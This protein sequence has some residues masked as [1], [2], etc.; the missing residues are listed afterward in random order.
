MPKKSKGSTSAAAEEDQPEEHQRGETHQVAHGKCAKL[1]TN[2][3]IY[4]SDNQ[5]ALVAG[6]RGPVLLEDF[7]F[8][9]KIF[10][11][12]H[13]RIPERIV[14]AHG[15]GAHGYFETYESLSDITVADL[16]QRKGEKTPVFVRF[17]TVKGEKIE[18]VLGCSFFSPKKRD[19]SFF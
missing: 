8:R 6:P 1:Q 4:V 18:Q 15:F 16:F 3:G 10:A 9:E 12:D 13:E 7:M 11:F 14:H 5:N 17:S 2:Q 19:S